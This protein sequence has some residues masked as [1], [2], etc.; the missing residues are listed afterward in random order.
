[1]SS[2]YDHTG[3]LRRMGDDPQLFREMV[4]LLRSDAPRHLR[5]A[6]S[7]LCAGDW[8]TLERAAHT[9]KGLAANFGA[10]RA[11]S[12]AADVEQRAKRDPSPAL[13]DALAALEDAFHEL[14]GALPADNMVESQLSS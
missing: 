11:V 1:M 14:A 3:S 8:P 5:N 4:A 9:L 13:E 7:S 6:R 2:V 12:A 10:S